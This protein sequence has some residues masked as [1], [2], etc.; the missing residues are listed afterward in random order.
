MSRSR[1]RK[2]EVRVISTAVTDT[3]RSKL[4]D[5]ALVEACQALRENEG[6]GSWEEAVETVEAIREP[7]FRK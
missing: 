4:R 7:K 1:Q 3:L 5:R 6:I 2:R